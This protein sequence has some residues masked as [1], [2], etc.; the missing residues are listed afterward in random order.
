[1]VGKLNFSSSSGITVLGER[2]LFQNCH[3]VSSFRSF[4]TDHFYGVGLRPHVQLPIWIRGEPGYLSVSVITF[5]LSGMGDAT[6][7]YA[8][9]SVALGII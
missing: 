1:M 9:A 4:S 5:K 2:S 8:I 6:S 7:S 3:P